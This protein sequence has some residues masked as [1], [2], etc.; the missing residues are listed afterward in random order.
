MWRW[1]VFVVAITMAHA[2]A[3]QSYMSKPVRLLVTS[4]AGGPSDFVARM[5]APGLGEG[6]RQ[7]VV[8]DARGSVGGIVAAEIAAKAAPDG[9]TLMVGNSGSH[10]INASLYRKLPYDAQRDFA[11]ISQL[12]ST[13]VVLVAN[14]KFAANSVSELIAAARK[15][16]GKFN[17]AVPGSTGEIIIE[18]LKARTQVKLTNVPYR[19]SAPAEFAVLSGEADLTLLTVAASTVHLNA[20]RMKALAVSGAKRSSLLPNVPTIAESGVEG[21]EIEMWHALFAP[22]RTPDKIVRMLQ[23]EVVRILNAPETRDRIVSAGYE[24]VASTPEQLAVVVKRDTEK[25]RKIVSEAGI[26]VE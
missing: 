10:A 9:S 12:V 17:V 25:Y 7:N 15:Q 22:A 24:I 6:L 11:P 14:P 2:A 21:F 13:S 16:P 19:G 3:A 20:G 5:I 1:V 23:R 26:Q 4:V 18:A 8:V